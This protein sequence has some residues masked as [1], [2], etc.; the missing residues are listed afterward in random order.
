[1]RRE[2][3]KLPLP[4]HFQK[5]SRPVEKTVSAALYL[6]VFWFRVVCTFKKDRQKY[7]QL[8][9]IPQG[10]RLLEVLLNLFIIQ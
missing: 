8:I 7:R 6:T 9:R 1:M 2:G 5:T 3:Y 10:S 4:V